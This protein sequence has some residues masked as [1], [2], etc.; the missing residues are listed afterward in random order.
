MSEPKRLML[1]V[2]GEYHFE[3]PHCEGHC[4][5]IGLCY[6]QPWS[7]EVTPESTDIPLCK[8]CTLPM[9]ES[10][11]RCLKCQAVCHV[12]CIAKHTCDVTKIESF[13]PL[14]DQGGDWSREAQ[15]AIDDLERTLARWR[16]I[17]SRA[18][19]HYNA[20]IDAVHV[21]IRLLKRTIT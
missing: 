17:D 15:R 18:H 9:V 4:K 2:T 13:V 11:V 16:I 3:N 19:D 8:W 20:F 14:P 6:E 10:R 21:V 5:F 12:T 7:S 1:A